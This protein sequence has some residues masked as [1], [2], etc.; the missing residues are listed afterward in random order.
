MGA[1]WGPFHGVRKVWDEYF[2]HKPYRAHSMGIASGLRSTLIFALCRHG[3]PRLISSLR[4]ACPTPQ[5]MAWK[6]WPGACSMERC[7]LIRSTNRKLSSCMQAPMVR[8]PF[9]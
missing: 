9:P 5:V 1:P 6:T 8:F 4:F 3:L 2:G 7:P